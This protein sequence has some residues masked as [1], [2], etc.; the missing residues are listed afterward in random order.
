MELDI[1]EV[2][3]KREIYGKRK[4]SSAG[5]GL[6]D[7]KKVCVMWGV[8]NFLP[9]MGEDEDEETMAAHEKRLQHQSQLSTAGFPKGVQNMG[10]RGRGAAAPQNGRGASVKTWGEHRGSLKCCRKIPVKEFI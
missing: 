5:K 9:P 7:F 6:I 3:A 2:K 4:G 8:K 10:G 1:P